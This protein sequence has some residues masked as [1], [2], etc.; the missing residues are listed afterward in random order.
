MV[1]QAHAEMETELTC[2]EELILLALDEESG[3]LTGSREQRRYAVAGAVLM[4]LALEARI[5]LGGKRFHVIDRTPTGIS[6]LD[7]IL[8]AIVGRPEVR[9]ISGWLTRIGH[10]SARIEEAAV[11]RLVEQ[12]LVRCQERRVLG[13][14]P[15]YCHPTTDG[16]AERRLKRR[17]VDALFGD[18]ALSRRDAALVAMVDAAG[19]L[20]AVLSRKEAH[21]ASARTAEARRSSG[22]GAVM[23]EIRRRADLAVQAQWQSHYPI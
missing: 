8:G 9:G 3:R 21:R 16:R 14:F 1:G 2:V 12:Q 10:R 5:E 7:E 19:L 4:D 22:V 11:E 18:D 20:E 6:Y 17:L 23:Q 15:S 13:L